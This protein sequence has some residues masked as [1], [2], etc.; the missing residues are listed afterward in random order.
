[1]PEASSLYFGPY[2]LMGP[3]GPLLI[4][5]RR[6]DLK[7]KALGVLWELVRQAGEIVTKDA[8]HERLWPT[9]VVGEDALAFQI[10]ALRRVLEDDAKQPRYIETCHR[11]GYTFIAQVTPERR[12]TARRLEDVA[13]RITTDTLPPSPTFVGRDAPLAQLDR[14]YAKALRGERQLVLINGE[15]GIGKTSLVQSFL[16]RLPHAPNLGYGQCVEQ[17][18]AGEGYRPV[19][20]ALASLCR[21]PQGAQVVDVLQQTAP[22]WL[23]QLPALLSPDDV[24]LL[25]ARVAGAPRERMLREIA[26]ALEAISTEMPLILVLEDLHWSDP[27]T[28]EMLALVA[29]R[30]A[31]A[32]LLILGTYRPADVSF[33][34][35]PLKAMKQEL[36]ARAQAG[37][38]PLG[39]LPP[40]D[41]QTYLARRFPETGDEAALSAF[42]YQRTE[43]HPLFMVQMADYLAADQ[44]PEKGASAAKDRL[45]AAIPQGL[46]ELIEVQLGRLDERE[47]RVLEI[48][49]VPGAEFAV[50]SIAAAVQM[51][52]EEAETCFEQLARHGQ[53]IEGRGLAAWPDGTVSGRYG[54]RHALYRDVLYSRMSARQRAQAHRAIGS[55]EERA[56]VERA[57][58]IAAELAVHF[59]RGQ[60]P[61]RAVHYSHAAGER[62]LQRSANAEATAHFTKALDLLATL[63]ATAERAKRELRL[64]VSLSFCLTMTKGYS[65][66]DAERV[67]ARAYA[68]CEQMEETPAI[69]SALFRIGRFHLVRGEIRTARAIGDRLLRIARHAESPTL[70]SQAHTAASFEY[71]SLGD[72]AAAQE[73][74][75]Q[76][77]V[78][79]DP[80]RYQGSAN[81]SVDDSSAVSQCVRAFA[82]QIR[83]YPDQARLGLHKGAT[84]ARGFGVPFA[85]GGTLLST[86][87]LH[88]MRRESRA[89][90]ETAEALIAYAVREGFPYY[91]ARATMLRGWALADQGQAEAGI[92][93]IRTGLGMFEVAGARQWIPCCLGL[94]AEAYGRA[95]NAE[96]GLRVLAEALE[97]AGKTSE[98]QYEAELHRIKG[99]LSLQEPLTNCAQAEAC[100]QMAITIARR[101]EAKIYELRA[102][103]SLARSSTQRS[104]RAAARKALS[105]VTAW[106]TEGFDT[107]DLVAAKALLAETATERSV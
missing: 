65:A 88:L 100:F 90:Q 76:S 1:M 51:P 9:T 72:F 77:I 3:Q 107:Q 73:H 75:E 49:S 93:E 69:S 37:E 14:H 84:L 87:D 12:Q 50:A 31:P 99:E 29:R 63:P 8:L 35:H 79:D 13:S 20:E 96:Q 41:V 58:E 47:R 103:L 22:T 32:R 28:I 59:E 95:G 64:Q 97:I 55:C 40:A 89:V 45:E 21:Q 82:L 24:K 7:P 57:V 43:G 70:L 52:E 11:V 33:T 102:A 2:R 5:T 25:Q 66:P 74:A 61:A 42:V 68:L 16:S 67:N 83:G 106:F 98:R 39:N 17:H 62:A 34:N 56:Y 53:F 54:F 48:A 36:V 44:A 104:K 94:L 91:V 80:R 38:I 46:R 86:A 4:G 27:S 15:A 78:L 81:V 85:T 30:T 23:M 60:D 10:Q 26:D 71:F 6:L 18:G 105:D 19:L 101:Q 92:A